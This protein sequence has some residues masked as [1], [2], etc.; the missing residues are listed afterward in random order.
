MAGV[1]P[2]R[3]EEIGGTRINLRGKAAYT[4]ARLAA[5]RWLTAGGAN[6][7][8][9][10]QNLLFTEIFG[11]RNAVIMGVLNGL[12]V[13]TVAQYLAGGF[14]FR[15]FIAIEIGLAICRLGVARRGA[16][17]SRMGKPT[18]TDMYLI[19]AICWCVLQGA[20][21]FAAMRTGNPV[22]ETLAIG[23]AIGLAGQ[24][25]ARDYPAPRFAWLLVGLCGLPLV[26]GMLL[27]GNHWM[28]LILPP[29]LL[30][31]LGCVSLIR[32]LHRMAVARFEAEYLSKQL[33]ERDPLTGL[34]NQ[35][36][37]ADV[38]RGLEAVG[39]RFVLFYLDLD[40]FKEINDERGHPA[41]DELLQGVAVRLQ[42]MTRDSDAVARLG[43]DQF[44]IVTPNLGPTESAALA[45]SVI[46]RI[47]D[48]EYALG[49]EGLASVGVSVGYACWP[50]DGSTLDLLR[51]RAELALYGAKKAG[52]GVHRRFVGP[53]AS[54]YDEDTGWT[55]QDRRGA[56]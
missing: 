53:V 54:D 37:L 3:R 42:A 22:L 33:A 23:T 31:I 44:V 18:P 16:A 56:A 5:L 13:N 41:G 30:L 2:D 47:T 51:N 14:V 52:K 15:V 9:H 55:G 20:M 4:P 26:T 21:V 39:M 35:A 49:H 50:E 34:L 24:I 43:G 45:R 46:R 40:G 6:L 36:G 25:C 38:L 7:P 10:I 12:F 48:T 32:Q 8:P 11:S 17:A 19:L 28:P 29:M 1:T 27:T